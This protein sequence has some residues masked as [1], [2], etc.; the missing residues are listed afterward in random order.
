MVLFYGDIH[1]GN[2]QYSTSN[3]DNIS[4]TELESR[5]ALESILERSK[6]EDIDIMICT[7]DFFHQCNPIT[8]NIRWAIVWISRMDKIGKPHYIITGN[9]DVSS[10]SNSLAYI[11]SVDLKNT[12]F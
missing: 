8:E 3:I 11:K 4:D 1:L 9:H 5:N 12:I 6:K 7:G 2:K 10:Y